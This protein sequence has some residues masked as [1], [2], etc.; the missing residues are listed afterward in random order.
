MRRGGV[1]MLSTASLSRLM[2][3]I[4]IRGNSITRAPIAKTAISGA[5]SLR[6]DLLRRM[7]R[8]MVWVFRASGTDPTEYTPRKLAV[9]R[10]SRFNT[11]KFTKVR[12]RIIINTINEAAADIP[13][14]KVRKP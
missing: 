10:H 9:L 1:G 12:P 3:S 8:P 6:V 4:H 14:S 7:L 13:K 2:E 5:S 11:L